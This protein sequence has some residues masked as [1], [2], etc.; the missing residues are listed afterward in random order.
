MHMHEEWQEPIPQQG[1]GGI[2]LSEFTLYINGREYKEFG[3]FFEAENELKQ[4]RGR[5]DVAEI[6]LTYH[7]SGTD[8]KRKTEK[9]YQEY[10][11]TESRD[12]GNGIDSPSQAGPVSSTP[13]Q[14]HYPEKPV[15][16]GPVVR[17]TPKNKDMSFQDAAVE[18]AQLY[19]SF[20]ESNGGGLIK[21][22]VS[23]II[24]ESKSPRKNEYWLQLD[25]KVKNTDGLIVQIKNNTYSSEQIKPAVFDSNRRML[26]VILSESKKGVFDHCAP[27]DIIVFS[28]LRF[29]VR[30]V[31]EWY[32]RFGNCIKLPAGKPTVKE[33]DCSNLKQTPSSDQTLAIRG[34]LSEPFSYVWGAPGTGKT[35]FVLA[36]AVLAYLQAGKKILV[37]APTNNAVEQTLYGLLPVLE[38]AGLDYNK[39]VVR[40]GTANTD[41]L[42]K[43][44]GV[45]EDSG[46]SKAIAEI[47]DSLSSLQISMEEAEQAEKL[48]HD[49]LA[50]QQKRS[51][52]QEVTSSLDDLIPR[53]SE[54]SEQVLSLQASLNVA[55]KASSEKEAE[56]KD[57]ENNQAFYNQQAQDLLKRL[58]NPIYAVLSWFNK[59][60]EQK[61]IDTSLEKARYYEEKLARIQSE[62]DA[63][64]E[65]AD[66]LQ[67]SLTE[68]RASFERMILEVSRCVEISDE[69]S[70]AAKAIRP[71]NA[72]STIPMFQN[73]LEGILQT[74]AEESDRFSSV[75]NRSQPSFEEE[76]ETLKQKIEALKNKQRELEQ[77]DPKKRMEECLVV[78]CTIDLCLNRLPISKENRFAHVFLDEAGYSSLIKAATLTAFSDKVT[79]LG[80]HMQLPPVCEADDQAIE[81]DGNLLLALWAQSALHTETIFFDPVERICTDYLKK[82]N[83]PFR[84]MKK[85]DLLNSYR[86]GEALARVLADDVYDRGFRGNDGHDTRIF[87]IDAPKRPEQERRVSHSECD[88]IE[89]IIQNYGGLKESSGII[90]PYRKQ[91]KLLREMARR[92]RLQMDNV[93]TVHQSQGREWDNIFLS[94]TDTTDKFFTDSLNPYSDGKKVINTAVSRA[95]KNLVIVCDYKY[96]IKQRSQLIGKLLAVATELSVE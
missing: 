26:K 82:A 40:L 9:R 66:G 25:Q 1:G 48:F 17:E 81:R 70:S 41:F 87:Y 51:A 5:F 34:V 77:A 11:K 14:D 95:R 31:K 61:K 86:F 39:L 38:E 12:N 60:E 24:P 59:E 35:R 28:D 8:Q 53:L 2:K 32:K 58:H 4:H 96:W 68:A 10:A 92:N 69:L 20:L 67:S 73:T 84:T 76:R 78:A 85:H 56:R 42:A 91:V 72:A 15:L 63:Q 29:L 52:F 47:M 64:N 43:Y 21:Y 83:T 80:D 27:E 49:Y 54:A 36:R 62:I 16:K 50:F 46:Y 3:S 37:T 75:V 94:V 19:Y 93:V 18:S 7:V 45:C 44:P 30:R 89:R 55:L 74:F 79:F 71:E 57:C 22:R 33:A 65:T 6:Y 23:K 13:R 88:S 90:A